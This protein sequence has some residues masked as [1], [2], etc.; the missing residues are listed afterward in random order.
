MITPGINVMEPV[1]PEVAAALRTFS[2]NGEQEDRERRERW[3]V[4]ETEYPEELLDD[5]AFTEYVE[6]LHNLGNYS[7]DQMTRFVTIWMRRIGPTLGGARHVT[8]A[9]LQ[10]ILDVAL[11]D[12]AHEA[13][14]HQLEGQMTEINQMDIYRLFNSMLGAIAQ[15]GGSDAEI[16]QFSVMV[17]HFHGVL[18]R[19]YLEVVGPGYVAPVTP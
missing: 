15:D 18:A 10:D 6:E 4:P 16:E 5:E 9:F 1:T 19:R 8:V 2:Q 17:E 11:A 7:P 3:G 14:D 12:S 13:D